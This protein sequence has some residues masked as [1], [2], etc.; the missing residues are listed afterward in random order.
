MLV[1]MDDESMKF[2][3]A[4]MTDD[5]EEE[6]LRLVHNEQTKLCA[7]FWNSAG[8]IALGGIAVTAS[9][10]QRGTEHM[11]L[12]GG[13]MMMGILGAVAAHAYAR[14]CHSACKI[15]PVSRGIGVQN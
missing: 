11:A 4:G 15:D 7:T 8:L 3:G 5:K 2:E 6:R 9:L 13:M 14:H 12:H 1:K 10:S